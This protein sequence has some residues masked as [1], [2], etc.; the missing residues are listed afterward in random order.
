LAL[1]FFVVHFFCIVSPRG[2]QLEFL[3][4]RVFHFEVLL[5]PQ[6]I[7]LMSPDNADEFNS[8]TSLLNRISNSIEADFVSLDQILENVGSSAYGALLIIPALI[9][10]APT[11]AIPGMSI[12]TGAI[13]M[14]VGIQILLS[15]D[16][17]WLP[18]SI[19][20]KKISRKKILSAIST[21]EPYVSKADYI[22][23]PRLTFLAKRPS[24]Y[25][26]AVICIFLAMSMFPLA[27][28]PFAVAMPAT[29][30]LLFGIG[31]TTK[32]GS[33]ILVGFFFTGLAAWLTYTT[34]A[35]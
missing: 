15:A 28:L 31:L 34:V 6:S 32:D 23:K 5:R 27:L 14:G 26:V 8:L 19:T 35:T 1:P 12:L 22:L 9:A 24:I 33:V 29:A 4:I 20:S 18:H 30:V 3:V 21:I 7:L 2:D 17:V 16:R 25:F 10:I 11:G 13:I